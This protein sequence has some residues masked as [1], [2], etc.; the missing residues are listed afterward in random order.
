MSADITG[1]QR[2]DEWYEKRLGRA[3]ASRFKDVMASIKTGEA[4]SRR[5]YRAELVA[6]RLTGQKADGFTS[7]EMQHGIDYED[8]AK[9]AYWL[10]TGREII[11][12]GF[13]CH[14]TIMAGA[15]PDGL[16][17]LDG[18]V[19]IKCPKTATHIETLKT[20][21]FPPQYYWQVMGQMWITGA[22][23][24]DFVSFDPRMPANSR[25]FIKRIE[26]DDL[27]IGRLETQVRLFLQE[28][29]DDEQFIKQI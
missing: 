1:D 12:C 29:K 21:K 19:E 23:W 25:L 16:V 6:E 7:K 2:T 3:T 28:V 13:Y 11:D 5:D 27:A 18:L 24:C 17:G 20:Q 10:H 4:A 14:D 15:S 22:A 9:L 26:R 8:A